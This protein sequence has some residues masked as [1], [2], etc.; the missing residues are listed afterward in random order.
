MTILTV[1]F[2]LVRLV[3]RKPSKRFRFSALWLLVV[4]GACTN[5]YAE[6]YIRALDP[7]S[8]S[9]IAAS[10]YSSADG[11]VIGDG[12]TPITLPIRKSDY[13]YP[14]KIVSIVV[15]APGRR[16]VVHNFILSKW[17]KTP[18]EASLNANNVDVFL[19]RDCDCGTPE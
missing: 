3:V 6:I 10:V 1:V 15:D 16:A 5:Q 14:N 12:E 9:N 8:G 2:S 4:L 13:W 11:Q 18:A 19:P 17:A 7:G